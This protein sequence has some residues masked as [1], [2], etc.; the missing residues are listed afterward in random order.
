VEE[1]EPTMLKRT[2]A[3]LAVLAL[4]LLA[5]CGDD[6]GGDDLGLNG[7]TTTDEEPEESTTTEEPEESTTTTSE[8]E[9]TTTTTDGGGGGIPTTGDPVVDEML[10]EC[11]DGNGIACDQAYA[12]TESG[13]DAEAFADTC[14]ET[15]DPGTICA[16][17]LGGAKVEPERTEGTSYG[18]DPD[19]DS[20]YDNCEGGDMPQCDLLFL[21]SPIGSEYEEFGGTCGGIFTVDDAPFS[22]AADGGGDGG[23]GGDD[24]FTYGDDPELD[25]LWDACDG[26]DPDACDQLFSDSPGGS[27]YEDFG[28]S[29]GGRVPEGEVEICSDIM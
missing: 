6:D 5:G 15:E 8:P 3:I 26:G 13:S 24:P 1:N 23:D 9:E 11:A 27:E 29:C 19:F 2:L 28:F 21:T 10:A 12:L 18:D 22:C 17:I 16:A 14:G 20:Y 4:A 7:S 25:A